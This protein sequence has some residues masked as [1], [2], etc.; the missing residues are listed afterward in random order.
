[1]NFL[2]PHKSDMIDGFVDLEVFLIWGFLDASVL[3]IESGAPE[4]EH[5]RSESDMS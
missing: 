5:N 1:M 2:L 3:L 4:D